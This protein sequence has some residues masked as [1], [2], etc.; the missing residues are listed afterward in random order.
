M[1]VHPKG[2]NAVQDDKEKDKDG[3]EN[4]GMPGTGTNYARRIGIVKHI[5][6]TDNVETTANYN[7]RKTSEHGHESWE[8]VKKEVFADVGDEIKILIGQGTQAI[9]PFGPS[10]GFDPVD[11][12]DI[13]AS[14]NLKVLVTTSCLLLDLLL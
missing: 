4:A 9:I 14:I 12:S 2:G 3:S 8:N 11:L 7:V 10:P 6:A 1:D 13:R 5:R